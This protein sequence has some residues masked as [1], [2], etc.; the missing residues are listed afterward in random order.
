M[1]IV[2]RAVDWAFR[3]PRTGRL[4]VAQLPNVALWIFLVTVVLQRVIDEDHGVHEVVAWVGVAALAWWALDELRR[5]VNP[6]RR[7]LGLLGLVLVALRAADL[8]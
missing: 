6:W 5:G 4:V 3:D 2:R 8:L 7:L 1:A